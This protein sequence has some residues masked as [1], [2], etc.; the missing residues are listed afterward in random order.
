MRNKYHAKKIF[1]P[2]DGLFDSKKEYNRW[3]YLK[4]EEEKGRITNLQRQVPFEVIPQQRDEFGKVIE[5]AA[6]YVADFVYGDNDNQLVVEDTKGF[7]TSDYII[8][9]KLMLFRFGIRIHEV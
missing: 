2:K 1:D 8:K 7:K 9:R 3:L 6:K 4:S 5:R